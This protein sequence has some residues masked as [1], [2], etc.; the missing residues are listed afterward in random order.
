MAVPN[1]SISIWLYNGDD[2]SR[3]VGS[4]DH[5]F[6][7]AKEEEFN[8]FQTIIKETPIKV[9]KI[10]LVGS[11]ESKPLLFSM[12]L[13]SPGSDFSIS[14]FMKEGSESIDFQYIQP[15]NTEIK[16][17]DFTLNLSYIKFVG[18]RNLKLTPKSL[19]LTKVLGGAFYSI[20]CSENL[21]LDGSS[22][23]LSNSFA[24]SSI[25]V[26]TSTLY[27]G[28]ILFLPRKFENT[29]KLTAQFQISGF[30]CE[31]PCV[32]QSSAFILS[33]T[34]IFNVNIDTDASLL[35][36]KPFPIDFARSGKDVLTFHNQINIT[37]TGNADPK[38]FSDFNGFLPNFVLKL[39]QTNK[40]VFT[41]KY[42]PFP[43]SFDKDSIF[44]VS[45]PISFNYPLDVE[46][47]LTINPFEQD[48]DRIEVK[49]PKITLKENGNI[50][51]ASNIELIQ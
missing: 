26:T 19:K 46:H 49:I 15:I 33:P 47:N 12:D 31:E 34:T 23:P 35:D 39:P 37:I 2:N 36:D 11:S 21:I 20:D 30:A 3:C 8:N 5:T 25:S 50:I 13:L 17:S 7:Y 4:Y 44:I 48:E 14:P 45:S 38:V 6:N 22:V 1:Q 16:S 42:V 9:F 24:A 51:K 18:V 27:L 40:Y 43:I 41:G 10:T 29:F 28:K 32:R